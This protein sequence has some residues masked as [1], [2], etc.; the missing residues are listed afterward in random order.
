MSGNGGSA[1]RQTREI[2]IRT[3]ADLFA[4]NGYHATGI[5]ELL[6]ACG[7]SR[8]ALYYHMD[9]KESL[10]F[11][12][13]KTQVTN[14]NAI[15][16]EIAQSDGSAEDR[17]RS[18]ARA[19]IRN[20]SDHRAEWIVFFREFDG[21]TGT[22]RDQILRAR[23]RYERYWAEVLESGGRAGE[24]SPVNPL[25]V[26]GILGMLNYT[27]LWISPDGRLTPEEIAET[28]VDLLMNGLR[29]RPLTAPSG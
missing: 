28:F 2:I 5:A 3:A 4:L 6:T 19:L 17:V 29:P 11:E 27:Y 18:M 24:L 14:M 9:G 16:E 1:R 22:R 8:G 7:I 15:A 23:E 10:L 13:C 25:H 20:I 12:I 26:K 21:L